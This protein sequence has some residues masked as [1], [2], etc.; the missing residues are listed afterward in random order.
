MFG[1]GFWN[2]SFAKEPRL[3]LVNG[4][5]GLSMLVWIAGGISR[6]LARDFT[7][8][9]T[10]RGKIRSRRIYAIFAMVRALAGVL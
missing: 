5:V 4:S 3:K 1:N 7:Y 2:I 8:A 9:R 10:C 6:L